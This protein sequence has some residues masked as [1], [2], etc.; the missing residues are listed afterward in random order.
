VSVPQELEEGAGG[1]LR[2]SEPGFAWEESVGRLV[3]AA[4]A[5]DVGAGDWTTL[6]T[7]APEARGVADVVAKGEMI[8]AGGDVAVEVFRRVDRDIAANPLAR[9]G[10]KVKPGDVVLRLEGPLRGILTGERTALNFLGRLS[11][12]AT[13]TRRFVDAVAGTGVEIQDTRKTTP[14]LRILEKEAVRAGGGRNHRLGLYDMVLVKDNHLVVAGGVVAAVERVRRENRS[15]LPV[16]VE[17]GSLNE[18]EEALPLGVERVLLD[19][20]DAETMAE[21]VLRVRAL[22][23][24]RPLV[25]ASGNVTV[26]TV[27]RVAETGVDIISVGAL[28]HSAP[29]ADLSLRVFER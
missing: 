24:G 23:P 25:E 29:V 2:G 4:L 1:P 3:E 28:T 9:D 15:G 16:E 20:M 6:W 27:R 13:L 8:V 5:E 14:G 26:D 10:Q 12:V 22:G 7:V 18:L 21:A 11:G 19:N 17:V